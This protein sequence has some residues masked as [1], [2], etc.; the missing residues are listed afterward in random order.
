MNVNLFNYILLLIVVVVNI[1][2]II[3]GDCLHYNDTCLSSRRKPMIVKSG[4]G[5]IAGDQAS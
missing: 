5:Q 3:K 4:F 2:V 1:I